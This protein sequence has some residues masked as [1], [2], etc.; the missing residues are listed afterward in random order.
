VAIESA[1][2]DL[3]DSQL[4]PACGA[5]GRF[6]KH[7]RYQKYHFAV[8]IDIQRVVCH[9]CGTTHA[10]IPCFSIPDTS[11]GTEEAERSLVQRKAGA[12]RSVAD[13]A[14]VQQGMEERSGRRLEKMLNTAVERGKAIWPLAAELSLQGLVWIHAVCGGAEHPILDFNRWALEHGVNAICFCR[15]S[16]LFFRFCALVERG[17]HKGASAAESRVPL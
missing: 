2:A 10:M 14:L 9:A 12:S 16:I 8:R 6:G 4:C 3:V 15:G 5:R 11:L 1:W 17:P 7:A 13:S